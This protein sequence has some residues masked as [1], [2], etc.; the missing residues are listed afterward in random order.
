MIPAALLARLPLLTDGRPGDWLRQQHSRVA[1]PVEALNLRRPD[2]VQV[3]HSEF[4]GAG[5]RV[6][7]TNTRFASAPTLARHG[8]DDRCE[9]INNSGAACVRQAVGQQAVLLGSIGEIGTESGL[10]AGLR[11]SAADRERAY[12]Q[13]AVYLSDTGC[14]VLLLEGFGSVDECLLVL[15]LVRGAGDAPVL[16]LLALDAAGQTGDGLPVGAAARRLADAG[17]DAVGLLCGPEHA[18]LLEPALAARE[19][20]VPVAVLLQAWPMALG[21]E[22]PPEGI[23]DPLSVQGFAQRL[24]PLASVAALLGGGAGI[25]PAHVKALAATLAR[26]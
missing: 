11:P 6:L 26:G 10:V 3:A 22:R 14:D 7:R 2:W 1:G 16:A 25:T 20:G 18:S 8:L 13:Q 12:G 4:F 15:R 9:A 23:R 17:M 19:A 24:A 21:Q 5:A